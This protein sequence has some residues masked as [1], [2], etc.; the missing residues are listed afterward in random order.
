MADWNF[1]V[2]SHEAT[3]PWCDEFNYAPEHAPSVNL[4]RSAGTPEAEPQ[5]T[6]SRSKAAAAVIVVLLALGLFYYAALY[7]PGRGTSSQATQ[8]SGS[9]TLTTASGLTSLSTASQ[10][11]SS[12]PFQIVNPTFVNG[13]ANI[14]VP[15]DY[16]AL[17][18]FALNL[19]N[20][21]RNKAGLANVTL[22]AIQS[23]QQHSDSMA[24]F[25]YL[26][27]WDTQGYKPYMRYTMMGGSGGVE[28]NAALDYCTNSPANATGVIPT[29]CTLQTIE[30]G[31]ANAEWAM[32]N[33]DVQCCNNGHRENILNPIH[34]KI[35]IGIAWNST[36]Q[37][38]YFDEDFEDA[39]TSFKM[40]LYSGGVVTLSG[41]TS[42]SI[43][44]TEVAVY[45]DPTPQPLNT[46]QLS[47]SPYND[48]YDAG[49]ALGAVFPPCAG[50]VLLCPPNTTD[51]GVAVYAS[52]WNLSPGAFEIQFDPSRFFAHGSG[53]YTLYMFD[54]GK[55]VYTSLSVVA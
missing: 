17:T 37:A 4:D 13:R 22:G 23:G 18:K 50:G 5:R 43:D 16:A 9:Q 51:G 29:D 20:T 40:P 33:N 1:N 26:S 35:S 15:G 27:H 24:Y 44:V 12:Q 54:S 8:N 11:T 19:I 21:D 41:T 25:G 48:G 32:M 52:V 3:Y 10:S 7:P 42:K 2:S 28:E 49:T 47:S 39:Y 34:N 14:S 36:T 45:Y 31:M 55:N 53:V 30:N 38:V 46:T 6:G